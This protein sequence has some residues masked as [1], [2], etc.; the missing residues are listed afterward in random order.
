M[1]QICGHSDKCFR[2]IAFL[3]F[4]KIQNIYGYVLLGS[5]RMITAKLGP[6]RINRFR[7]IAI[8]KAYFVVHYIFIS[9][10]DA[11]NY[12]ESILCTCISGELAIIKSIIVG[13]TIQTNLPFKI[14]DEWQKPLQS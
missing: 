14:Y 1:V 10:I 7:V 9:S 3:V 11:I 12:P 6:F 4:F 8:N 5:E 13:N 2:V